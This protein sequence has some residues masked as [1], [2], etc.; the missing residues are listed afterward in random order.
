[1]GSKKRMPSTKY[2]F[3]LQFFCSSQNE[4]GRF[5]KIQGKRGLGNILGVNFKNIENKKPSQ[6]GFF[7]ILKIDLKI[8]FYKTNFVNFIN[9][10]AFN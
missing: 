3:I 4:A 2:F 7:Y 9:I 10:I 1:M 8:E 5:A 6:G